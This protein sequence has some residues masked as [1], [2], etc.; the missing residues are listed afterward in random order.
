MSEH[1]RVFEPH[2]NARQYVITK[3]GKSPKAVWVNPVPHLLG[4][5]DRL[6]PQACGATECY[7]IVDA[8]EECWA[9]MEPGA[10]PAACVQCGYFVE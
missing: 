6:C 7:L 3:P 4:D 10:V 8:D 9:A 5:G 1:G 2:E